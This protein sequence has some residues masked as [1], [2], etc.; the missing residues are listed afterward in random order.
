MVTTPFPKILMSQRQKPGSN[1]LTAILL[2]TTVF[3]GLQ[4]LTGPKTDQSTDKRKA[5]EIL[6]SMRKMDAL[7]QDVKIQAE[8]RVYEAKLKEEA[9]AAKTPESDLRQKLME[10]WVLA[11]H[12]STKAG[13]EFNDAHRLSNA[14]N[15]LDHERKAYLGDKEWREVKVPVYGVSAMPQKEIS[16][17]ELYQKTVG[18]L[19]ELN[20]HQLVW[21]FF[22]GYTVIDSFV[23]VTGSQP[24]ISYT[25]AAFLLALIVRAIVYPLAQKQLMFSR[26]M[27]QLQPLAAEIKKKLTNKK[28][29][30]D[31]QKF[32]LESMQLYR[33]YGINPAAGCAPALAQMPLFLLV[34]QSMLLYRFE[35]SKG[36][37]AWINPATSA[38]TNHIFAA[39]LGQTDYLLLVVYGVSMVIATYLQPVTDPNNMKQQ[40]LMGIGVS[41]M[42]TV[43]MF[44]YPL[45]S[46][47][48]LYWIFLN[49]FSTLQSLRA[50]R[51]PVPPLQKVA[52]PAGGVRSKSGFFAKLMEEQQRAQEE[53]LREK[54]RSGEKT[55]AGEKNGK[56]AVHTE[57]EDGGEEQKLYKPQN[58]KKTKQ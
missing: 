36:L 18:K 27:M 50:Y 33:E 35:F 44:F 1:L 3:L 45:P 43:M 9:K 30:V 55:E 31:Q 12:T 48:V 32:Q 52:T 57:D 28:G 10:S 22:P 37:F 38:G 54:I 13:F 7:G 47:F 56:A 34:F 40:R 11:M 46:A 49:I 14:F 6:S 15:A 5:S 29:E 41:V 19:G 39:N 25:L 8:R 24:W 42:V 23:T 16:G 21:G 58:G 2:A 4:L 26:Q 17:E 53:M 20:K 51:L